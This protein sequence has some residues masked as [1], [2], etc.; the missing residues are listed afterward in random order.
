MDSTTYQDNGFDSGIWD[1]CKSTQE[2]HVI[3]L[4]MFFGNTNYINP[5][6]SW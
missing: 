6:L 2:S 5:G 4:P 3:S 1:L